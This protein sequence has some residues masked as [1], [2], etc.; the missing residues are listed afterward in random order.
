MSEF[1]VAPQPGAP[2]LTDAFAALWWPQGGLLGSL[3]AASPWSS[4]LAGGIPLGHLTLGWAQACALTSYCGR[5]KEGKA[6]S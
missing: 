3:E 2:S 5:C 1:P 4:W 6:A